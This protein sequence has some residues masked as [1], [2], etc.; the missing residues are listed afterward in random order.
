MTD[1]RVSL[2]EG[3]ARD[4]VVVTVDGATVLDEGGVT[5][6]LQIG[7]AKSVDAQVPNGTAPP[8][9]VDVRVELPERGIA[10][11]LTLDPAATPYLRVS[12][13]RGHLELTPTGSPPYYA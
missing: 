2:E 9:P 12:I 11:A 5:T 13:T 3:F 6:A 4:H 8:A 10:S 1:L 7:L